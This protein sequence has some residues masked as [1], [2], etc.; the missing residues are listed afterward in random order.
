MKLLGKATVISIYLGS[1]LMA[2]ASYPVA[3]SAFS[4]RGDAA[5]AT[6][7]EHK[8]SLQITPVADGKPLSL[9]VSINDDGLIGCRVFFDSSSRYVAVGAYHLGLETGPLTVAVADL[10]TNKLIGSFVVQP[11]ASMGASLKLAGFL[12]TNPILVVLG[13]GA[14]DHP[15]KAFSSTG[16]TVNGEQSDPPET[17]TLPADA[18]SVG[19]ISFADAAH[20]RLWFKSSPQFCPLR[21]VPLLGTG[22]DKAAVDE[23]GAKAACDVE[24]AI[25][26]PTED[27]LITA[28]TRDSGD[29]VTRVDLAQH[30]VD[31]IT[32]A[33]AGSH[34]DYTSVGH[35][36]L[37]ADG[38]VFAIVRILLANSLFGGAH[39]RGT[40]LDVVQV[41]PLK[42]IGTVRLKPGT[43]TASISIGHR[44]GMVTVLSYENGRWDSERLKAQ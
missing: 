14:P 15:V 4:G 24:S 10:A 37:S 8:L 7:T 19:N 31:Q 17:R 30:S 23:P 41:S 1:C 34:R 20:N 16:F 38:E 26:Y 11:S 3:C 29:L 39:S 35:G 22:S 42:I 2:R 40:E 44:N 33:N 32:L 12:R 43:D 13:S 27:T 18:E 28:V 21:S 6:L 5:T 25:A 36:V 9:S